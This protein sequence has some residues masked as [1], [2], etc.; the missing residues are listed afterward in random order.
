MSELLPQSRMPHIQ[1]GSRI[2]ITPL[3][4]ASG[5]RITATAYPCIDVPENPFEVRDQFEAVFE[6]FDGEKLKV[7][8][9]RYYCLVIF[10][11]EIRDI[12]V[13]SQETKGCL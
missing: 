2:M 4:K 1:K 8:T 5:D 12:R 3:N 11:K 6:D 10:I 13:L 9:P 7:R